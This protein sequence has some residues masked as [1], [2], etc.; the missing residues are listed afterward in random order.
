MFK[1]DLNQLENFLDLVVFEC[2]G[3]MYGELAKF[4]CDCHDVDNCF[5]CWNA[6]FCR[7]QEE[8]SLKSMND[9][10]EK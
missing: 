2:P 8:V 7:Y 4:Q 3:E 1:P 5:D 10:E 6:T 9:E